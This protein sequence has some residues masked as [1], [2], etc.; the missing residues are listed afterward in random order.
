[1]KKIKSITAVV[2]ATILCIFAA[3]CTTSGITTISEK[4]LGCVY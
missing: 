3:G 1:M 2:L 4:R